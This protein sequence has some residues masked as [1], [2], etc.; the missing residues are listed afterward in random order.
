[1]FLSVEKALTV[2]FAISH[3][4]NVE[5]L[6]ITVEE[7]ASATDLTR[8]ESSSVE[9]IAFWE[10]VAAYTMHFIMLPVSIVK[11]SIQE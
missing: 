5:I 1:M 7:E 9:I 10:K 2:I 11:V 8:D 4:P 3:F 6:V